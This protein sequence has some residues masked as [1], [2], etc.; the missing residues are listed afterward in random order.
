[1][2]ASGTIPFSQRLTDR[3]RQGCDLTNP[4]RDC[5]YARAIETESINHRLCQSVLLGS[6][7]VSGIGLENRRLARDQPISHREENRVLLRSR[8]IAESER[9]FPRAL[10]HVEDLLFQDVHNIV[11]PRLGV[12]ACP[13][14]IHPQT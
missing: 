4:I 10:S 2:N 9:R 1:M 13:W 14:E 5:I 7:K 8:Q 12:V 11:I 3:I 6:G